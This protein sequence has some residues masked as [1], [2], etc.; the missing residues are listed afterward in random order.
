MWCA[1]LL[2]LAAPVHAA[3][4]Y[5]TDD[6]EP[7]DTGHWE[8][9]NFALGNHVP[10][11]TAGQAGLDFNYG[12]AENL[13]L[14]AVFPLQY[15]NQGQLGLGNIELAAKYRFLDPA[16]DSVL[17]HLAFFPRLF[18]PTAGRQFG[19]GHPNL[20]LPIW[21]GKDWGQ[22]SLFGGGGY[23]INPGAGNRNYWLG[24]IVLSRAVTEAFS[25]GVELYRQTG[26]TTDG[27]DFTGL[28][29]GATYRFTEHWSL[30]LSGGPGL[31]N[32]RREGE[33][34]FYAALKADY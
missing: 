24:G 1:T 31:E 29:I 20:L 27:R 14:T 13:Q 8:V 32:A 11:T 21:A 4:P 18:A 10:G 17:P 23:T 33:Y 16:E 26:T 6:P 12:A 7:T 22:S 34:A 3:P 5:I 19:T 15:Q 28:N 30:L 25:L 9:Y 2:A